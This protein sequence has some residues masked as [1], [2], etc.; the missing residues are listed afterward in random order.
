[1]FHFYMPHEHNARREQNDYS[2]AK[3]TLTKLLQIQG[4]NIMLTNVFFV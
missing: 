1:M 4:F 3:W 2:A